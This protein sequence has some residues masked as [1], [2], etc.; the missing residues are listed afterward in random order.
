MGKSN[1]SQG[2]QFLANYSIMILLHK[3][4]GQQKNIRLVVITH[5]P[6]LFH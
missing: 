4:E 6:L 5:P 1:F 2:G 3:G